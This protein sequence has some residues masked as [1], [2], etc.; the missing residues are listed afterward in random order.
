MSREPASVAEPASPV[1]S[2][3]PLFD[4]RAFLRNVPEEPGVYRMIG[5]GERVLYVGKAKNL[6]RRVSSYFQKTLSSPRI[7]MMVAQIERVDITPTRSE[8]EALILENNL[9]KSLAPRYNILFR[10]DKTYPHIELSAD[11]FPR[12]AYHRGAFTRGA[13][14][15]GPFPNVYA[16]RES[17]HLL[18]K[19]FQL[20]TC[21]NSAF[22]NRSRA[23]LLH[24]IKRCSAP[25][26]GQIDAEA[27]R[28]D[29]RLASRFL[30]GQANEV[31]DDLSAKMQAAAEK[32]AF[33]AAA[34]CR[35]QVRVLQAVLHRQFVDSRKDEDVDIIAAVEAGGWVCINIAMVRGGRHLGDRPQFP[36]GA[37]VVDARDGLLAFVEQHYAE[38]PAPTRILVAHEIEPVR[39]VLGEI[40]AQTPAVVLPRHVAEKAWMEMA[41]KN[42]HLAIE[43]R[44]RDAG[45]IGE[46]LQ[47]LREALD[48]A[49]LPARIECFDIS[50]TM[51]EA[52]VASCVV[53]VDGAMKKSEY[54]RYN[55]SGITPGDDFAAMRQALERRY[56]KV[57]AGEGVRPDLILIDGGRGQV[58]AAA[59]MLGEVGL[60]SINMV[61]V[62][63]GE[64]RKAGL[65]TLIF[66]DGSEGMA[67]GGHSPALHL[68]I[69]I[70]DEAHR[71]A[72]TGHRARRGKARL[73]SKLE[74]IPGVGPARRRNLLATFGGLDGVRNATV[75]D[76]CRVD[77]VSR[78]LAE[79]I[80]SGLH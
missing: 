36:S 73:S 54:R 12:L 51:G 47:A 25:C 66:P 35:D 65:E 45:R 2:S 64:G 46:R 8:A 69:E 17:I 44:S 40:M 59:A 1:S 33:E 80:Y 74:D 76:L 71:F 19:T 24:Q 62:A 77:G 41:E 30:D 50:H 79:Q 28:H 38:H 56:G 72:I 43:A 70:R 75:E 10:D 57:A 5:E 15:F 29:V 9:I 6:K 67:L 37:S 11:E 13:R 3:V 55:I 31:I 21:E 34:A 58:S 32:L 60:A 14:Y 53:C 18:Q 39:E 22:Q 49:E 63:K 42:A 16:V 68:V 20:R 23:C 52:T 7:A 27:Y 26:V 61:G 4:S 48:L 78:K